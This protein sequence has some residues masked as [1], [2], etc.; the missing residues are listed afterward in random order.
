MWLIT[1]AMILGV[2]STDVLADTGANGL[3]SYV[4]EVSSDPATSA[5]PS[6]FGTGSDDGRVWADKSVSVNGSQFDVTLSALAQEYV[7][8][9]T[10]VVREQAAADVAIVIDMSGSMTAER[11]TRMK[12]AV[13]KGIDIIM[14]ANPKN[15]IGIYYY[16]LATGN[17]S[18]NPNTGTLLPL[19]SYSTADTG[20]G[21]D[22]A[23]RY[24]TS[25]DQT[26]TRKAGITQKYLNGATGT[27]TVQ[28]IS[29]SV[30]LPHNLGCTPPSMP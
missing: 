8:T 30:V 22:A 10:I 29:T 28:T 2:L 13:N 7:R 19:A 25:S 15:R 23:D 1:A 12:N 3:D 20:D 9:S 18:G 17:T 6:T 11:I 26:I 16:G 27:T 21:S 5:R 4:V 14:A 24:V